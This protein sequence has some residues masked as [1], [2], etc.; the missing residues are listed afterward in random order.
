MRKHLKKYFLP[1]KHNKYNPHFFRNTSVTIIFAV[2]AFLLGISYGNYKFLH[3]TVLGANIATNVLVDLANENRLDNKVP[4]LKRNDLLDTAASLKAEDMIA[5][6]YFAHFAP[7]GT[8][9]WYFIQK[10]GYQ[11][12]YAG[13][14]LAINFDTEKDVD[15]A[16]MGSPKH[17]ENLLNTNFQEIGMAAKNGVYEGND[18]VYIVQMFAS[19]EKPEKKETPE[20]LPP[21]KINVKI[22]Q[23]SKDFISVKNLDTQKPATATPVVAGVETYSTWYDRF[24]FDSSYYI[25]LFYIV[26]I[27]IIIFAI[28][29]RMIIEYKRQHTK[30]L[31]ISG[32]F[33]LSILVLAILNLNFVN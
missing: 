5:N 25:Q 24:I 14:N 22:V 2:S 3:E 33:L 11:F 18:T 30:H 17:R 28:L 6:N 20:L 23:E 16:W 21:E 8:T 31:I 15:E 19:P 1:G 26:L 4:L 9:P 13:E 32:L 29:L 10:A 7:D 12:T 27:I